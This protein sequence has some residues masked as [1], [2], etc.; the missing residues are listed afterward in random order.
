M[1][2]SDTRLADLQRQAAELEQKLKA[3]TFELDVLY[4]LSHQFS[5]SLTLEK[6]F[7]AILTNLEGAVAYD[8]AAGLL[9]TDENHHLYL[10]RRRPLAPRLQDEV[11]ARM[12]AAYRRLGHRP[13]EPA[14]PDMRLVL[15]EEGGPGGPPIERLGSFFQ[16]PI[17]A[18]AVTVGFLFIGS[19]A[20]NQFSEDQV[21]LLYTV[22]NQASGAVERLQSVLTTERRRLEAVVANLPEGVV[23]L[24]EDQRIT[25]TNPAG[26]DL[27]SALAG[28]R[29]G[30]VLTD[31]NGQSFE[32]ILKQSQFNS[33]P[34]LVIESLEGRTLQPAIIP[35]NAEPLPERWMLVLTDVTEARKALRDRDRFLAMLA[36]ELRNPLAPILNSTRLLGR[37]GGSS[38]MRKEARDVI[39][40][41]VQH[42]AR[43]VDD[44]LDVSR[45]LHNK[46][47]LQRRPFE[48]SELVTRTLETHR[49]S[50]ENHGQQLTSKICDE[51]IWIDGDSVRLSQVVSNLVGNATK[52][53][54]A[55]GRVHVSC[56]R[57]NNEAVIRVRDTGIGISPER[58]VDIFDPF[59]QIG[60]S[61]SHSEGG[62]GLGLALVRILVTLHGGAVEA[63][64]GGPEQGSEFMVR[65]PTI[66]PP[67]KAPV[68]RHQECL[69]QTRRVL[70]VEDNS[71]ARETLAQLLRLSGHQVEAAG[72]GPEGIEAFW[73]HRPDVALVDIGL[74]DLDGYE[75]ARRLRAD[76]RGCSAQLIALTGYA[77]PEDRRRTSEAGFD[78]HLVKPVDIDELERI[79][80]AP[81]P[82]APGGRLQN[83]GLQ[84]D[85]SE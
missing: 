17:M 59:I 1:P 3:R 38:L 84:S 65:L 43:L 20:A 18:N 74:P 55:G 9:V 40:R 82:D 8:V 83:Q 69:P 14:E 41:Q 27:L 68:R 24:D 25:M 76:S 4:E 22:A 64:S 33:S 12:L 36:H 62:L 13:A 37:R 53:T 79:L 30:D 15:V 75:V 66:P 42:M 78:I 81:A 21:R 52:Y 47:T 54:P 61:L 11:E 35:L 48:L 44:L 50:V 6:L 10:R 63:S 58:F 77:R 51:A 19:H 26:R 7:R 32:D 49:P 2:D 39:A 28:A 57:E 67:Q 34:D 45:Y 56:A 23:L 70:I 80:E 71:D 16:I 73:K 60:D 31:L 46:V 5:H 72:T 85:H 29:V